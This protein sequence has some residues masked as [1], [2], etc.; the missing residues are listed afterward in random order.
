MSGEL[1]AL[2]TTLCWSIGIFPFTEASKRIGTGPV[3][4]WRL[5]LAW[6]IMSGI[7]FFSNSLTLIDLF[8][9]PHFYHFVFL[10]LSG[11]IGFTIGDY[12]S[13]RSFTILGPKLGSLYTTAF[14]HY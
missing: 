8:S 6:L 9:K 13:F 5:L 2:I 4:Q 11:I 10:G 12:C 7:L 1:I 14:T 3:N